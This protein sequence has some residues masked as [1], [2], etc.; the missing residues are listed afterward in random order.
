MN[1]TDLLIERIKL[2]N[3][4]ELR[5]KA[6]EKM[7]KKTQKIVMNIIKKRLTHVA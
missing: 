3:N 4:K 6:F 7:D 1:K 5:D 2:F